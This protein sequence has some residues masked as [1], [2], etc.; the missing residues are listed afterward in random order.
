MQRSIAVIMLLFLPGIMVPQEQDWLPEG[1]E[2]YYANYP[3]GG[4]G[5]VT[6]QAI[7]VVSASE[8][9]SS[10][11][12]TFDGY[13]NGCESLSLYNAYLERVGGRV[14]YCLVS[15]SSRYLLYDFNAIEQD[16]VSFLGVFDN[17]DPKYSKYVVR[18]IDTVCLFDTLIE[19]ARVVSADFGVDEF[20]VYEYGGQIY[21]ELGGIGCLLSQNGVCDSHSGPLV[22][23]RHPVKGLHCFD[24]TLCALLLADQDYAPIR[25][26]NARFY[27][28]AEGNIYAVGIDKV[29]I[30][31]DTLR[32]FPH[33]SV[34]DSFDFLQKNN[35]CNAAS[36]SWMFH[37]LDYIND[38]T[39]IFYTGDYLLQ[40]G[41]PL[42][43]E[44][45]IN[46]RAEKGDTWLAMSSYNLNFDHFTLYASVV[47]KFEMEFLGIIDTVKLIGFHSPD[48]DSFDNLYVLLGKRTALVSAI[49]FRQINKYDQSYF[50]NDY[51]RQST[52]PLV[53]IE[54]GP[55]VY[56]ISWPDVW[57]FDVGDELHTQKYEQP[58][59]DLPKF[60]RIE[61]IW[62]ILE[63]D[64]LSGLN[65]FGYQ[66]DEHTRITKQD[67]SLSVSITRDTIYKEFFESEDFDALPGV[68][69]SSD[70][71]PYYHLGRAFGRMTK[72]FANWIS[73]NSTP[74]CL[75]L[76]AGEGCSSYVTYIEGL[77]GPYYSCQNIFGGGFYHNVLHYFRKGQETYGEPYD[78]S[79]SIQES[80]NV[81]LTDVLLFP[82]P[83]TAYLTVSTAREELALVEVI[84][85]LGRVVLTSSQAE[86]MVELDISALKSGTYMVRIY[87]RAKKALLT[88]FVKP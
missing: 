19:K 9:D 68:L 69:V 28:H 51:D 36:G 4:T 8:T 22:A 75:Q 3:W 10:Q 31:G 67:T 33:V 12:R 24:T 39:A 81:G 6:L 35:W 56:N 58:F 88:R 15:D 83:A 13:C 40:Y 60:T 26:L 82:N 43:D 20:A 66:I 34:T 46:T 54:Y 5:P 52:L 42:A 62:R 80:V 23:Y 11:I 85:M 74:S 87:T 30:S 47:D 45:K 63:K 70:S 29:D 18:D 17:Q 77:G 61:R 57:N 84:D 78:L 32:F 55:G 65:A 53:G 50:E 16:T 48:T 21:D 14:Y 37:H 79:T 49:N 7:A 1:A 76:S 41:F 25:D 44:F 64:Y 2:L 71:I 73:I 86:T 72:G 38:G 27:E 59:Y